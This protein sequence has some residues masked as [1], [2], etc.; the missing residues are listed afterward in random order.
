MIAVLA[1]GNAFL[2]G[3]IYASELGTG[4]VALTAGVFLAAG[5]LLIRRGNR[6]LGEYLAERG[7]APASGG[8]RI[9]NRRTPTQAEHGPLRSPG[10]A[11]PALI[12][13]SP[14]DPVPEG[15]IRVTDQ[16]GN[17]WALN[18]KAAVRDDDPTELTPDQIAR[19]RRFKEVLAE[20]DRTSLEQALAN[21]RRDRTPEGEIRRWELM[22]RVYAEELE[23]RPGAEEAERK[24]LFGAVFACSFMP[25]V[26]NV[27]S[28]IPGAKSLP[29]LER[30]VD[31]YQLY[32]GWTEP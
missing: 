11:T 24:H 32:S 25:T 31:R 23:A 16:Y 2:G 29:D 3:R 18:P 17:L 14:G 12:P 6:R 19:I 30:V 9:P 15:Y 1:V 4:P 8:R 26:E 13:R 27:L 22:A 5:L 21:F 20:H 28:M 10:A 7:K